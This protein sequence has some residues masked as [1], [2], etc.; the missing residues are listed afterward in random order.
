MYQHPMLA[1]TVTNGLFDDYAFAD[2][3]LCCSFGFLKE[4]WICSNLFRIFFL[5][6]YFC[7]RCRLNKEA[8]VCT[9]W[10]WADWMKCKES[11]KM[12]DWERFGMCQLDC[13]FGDKCGLPGF[14]YTPE[15]KHFFSVLHVWNV[16][17]G[18]C[19]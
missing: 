4:E 9:L 8:K 17:V 15:N 3:W 6:F 18:L 11:T 19:I 5:F 2:G 16:Q 1:N 13:K 14:F 7:K 10:S 12:R